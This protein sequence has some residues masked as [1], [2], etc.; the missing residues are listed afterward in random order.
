M[1]KITF[2]LFFYLLINLFTYSVV[3]AQDF[4]AQKAF[5]DYQYQ[6]SKYQTSSAEYADAKTFYKKNP[7]L[8]L[9]EEARKKT[10]TMLKDRDQLLIVY[11]TALRLQIKETTGF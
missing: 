5:Q 11:L 2:F 7:T 1:K 10:L 6:L 8:Q 9:Q 4:T 3:K